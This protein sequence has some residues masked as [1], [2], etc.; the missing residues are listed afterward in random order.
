MFRFLFFCCQENQKDKGH[1]VSLEDIINQQRNTDNITYTLQSNNKKND[2][3]EENNNNN[4][5]DFKKEDGNNKFSGKGLVLNNTGF[6]LNDNNLYNK[7]NVNNNNVN[8]GAPILTIN[9]INNINI[10][11][12]K[13]S[14]T[15]EPNQEIEKKDSVD[16][17]TPKNLSKDIK[18]F[19]KQKSI[20]SVDNSKDNQIQKKS[21]VSFSNLTIKYNYNG[22]SSINFSDTEIMSMC[23]LT[24]I[25]DIFFNKDIKIDRSG[26][27]TAVATNS[28]R[29]KNKNRK[30]CEIKFGVPYNGVKI[31]SSSLATKYN[32][33]KNNNKNGQNI[34]SSKNTKLMSLK[35]S[36]KKKIQSL[37]SITSLNTKNILDVV[38]NLSYTKVQKKL[39]ENKKNNNN[40]TND[41]II[42]F[43]LK[44]DTTLDLFQM[45]SYHENL[46][47]EL[48]LN[49]NYPLRFQQN[50]NILIGSVK[51]KLKVVKNDKNESEL[52]IVTYE[53]AEDKRVK[54]KNKN[55]NAEMVYK[56][57]PNIN[58]MPITIGRFN[59]DINLDNISVS[60]LHAQIDYIFDYDEYFII[61]C[62]STNGTYLL[63]KSPLNTIYIK[64]EYHFKLFESKFKI[65]NRDIQQL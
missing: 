65:Q 31:T 52:H 12:Q 9:N 58:K 43:S 29:Q 13:N 39:T 1:T 19:I 64:R 30:A 50:Y 14:F 20:I 3:E 25:G 55:E 60:K 47:V 4:N 42:L 23:E 61:D 62:K 24:L 32:D 49:Y 21:F 11:L 59:C 36:Q 51:M 5:S 10:N 54:N 27:K 53:K 38:L 45:K 2:N 37:S 7:N 63:L 8:P 33:E 34:N 56:F 41:N 44:Y 40:P 18:K 26:I 48:L 46:P 15:N 28:N 22:G 57:N 6:F 16:I 17:D 35:T